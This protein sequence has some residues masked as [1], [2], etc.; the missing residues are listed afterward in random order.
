MRR[1]SNVRTPLLTETHSCI[2]RAG[3]AASFTHPIGVASPAGVAGGI[4]IGTIV[5]RCHDQDGIAVNIDLGRN[6]STPGEA[7]RIYAPYLAPR[8]AERDSGRRWCRRWRRSRSRAVSPAGVEE[9][10]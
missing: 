3:R 8:G 4:G 1:R 9:D 10:L 5:R 6:R 2:I 7:H